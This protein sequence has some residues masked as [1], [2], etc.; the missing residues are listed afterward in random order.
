[1]QVLQNS[2]SS[3]SLFLRPCLRWI[4]VLLL[5]IYQLTCQNSLLFIFFHLLHF[6]RIMIHIWSA[7]YRNISPSLVEGTVLGGS[8]ANVNFWSCGIKNVNFQFHYQYTF[9]E[10]YLLLSHQRANDAWSGRGPAAARIIDLFQSIIFVY[11]CSEHVFLNF[12]ATL[13]Y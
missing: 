1:M 4:F 5:C 11:C 6:W 12:C 9:Q 10:T 8:C 2:A 7:W 13:K 3:F